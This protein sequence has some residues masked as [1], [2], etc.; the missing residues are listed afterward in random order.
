MYMCTLFVYTLYMQYH[1]YMKYSAS[2]NKQPKYWTIVHGGQK[3]N[4]MELAQK[5]HAS[6]D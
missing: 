6:R 2:G 4:E 5:I 3:C 1:L